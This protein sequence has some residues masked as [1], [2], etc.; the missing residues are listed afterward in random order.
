MRSPVRPAASHAAR[1]LNPAL[2]IHRGDDG[3]RNEIA[4][5]RR[6]RRLGDLAAIFAMRAMTAGPGSPPYHA[7]GM[8]ATHA[9]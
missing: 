6:V 7:V 2:V 4:G 1:E 3:R 9:D 8:A 5:R